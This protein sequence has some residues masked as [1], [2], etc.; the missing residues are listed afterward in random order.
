[1]LLN[2]CD[3]TLA[4]IA[5]GAKTIEAGGNKFDFNASVIGDGTTRV[6][7]TGTTSSRKPLNTAVHAAFP[8]AKSVQVNLN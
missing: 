8:K 1:M 6:R 2:T 4:E 7:I 3:Y 5:A